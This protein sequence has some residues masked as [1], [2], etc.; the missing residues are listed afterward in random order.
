MSLRSGVRPQTR[1]IGIHQRRFNLCRSNR[2]SD[3][4]AQGRGGNRCELLE[5]KRKA[6]QGIRSGSY[7]R[8][9]SFPLGRTTEERET[10]E[11]LRSDRR[12]G[13]GSGIVQTLQ[14]LP[15]TGRS[16]HHDHFGLFQLLVY[17]IGYDPSLVLG[18]DFEGVQV[19][20]HAVQ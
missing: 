11:T 13:R 12:Y 15:Q 16:V 6:R 14:R 3:R 19:C 7:L 18:W 8:L 4:Q 9:P 2:H 5:R 17:R 20:E 1:S 10:R